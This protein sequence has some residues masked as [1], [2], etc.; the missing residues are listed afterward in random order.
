MWFLTTSSRFRKPM[1][2]P[3]RVMSADTSPDRNLSFAMTKALLNAIVHMTL[4]LPSVNSLATISSWQ[5]DLALVIEHYSVPLGTPKA[6]V[7]CGPGNSCDTVTRL[8]SWM[9]SGMS[10]VQTLLTQTVPDSTSAYTLQSG[11]GASSNLCWLKSAPHVCDSD[12]I[13]IITISCTV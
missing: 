9:N 2:A 4:S 3:Y 8:Q 6:Q 5:V 11:G 13:I 7:V 12:V 1:K 10:C